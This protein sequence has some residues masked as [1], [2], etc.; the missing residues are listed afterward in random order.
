MGMS[1]VQILLKQIGID[2]KEVME[3]IEGFKTLAQ[4]MS[5][6]QTRIE[7]K[8]DEIIFY[9]RKAELEGDGEVR[10]VRNDVTDLL[11]GISMGLVPIDETD[12]HLDS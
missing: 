6:A 10:P 3:S 12:K 11:D 1:G 5:D 2:P 8:L 4:K 7:S 9:Q